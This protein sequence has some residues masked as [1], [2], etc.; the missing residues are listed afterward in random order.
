MNLF[1]M[2][3]ELNELKAEQRQSQDA[4]GKKAIAKKIDSLRQSLDELG[5]T[6]DREGLSERVIYLEA[7]PEGVMKLIE[8][9][10]EVQDTDNP[11]T[12]NELDELTKELGIEEAIFDVAK[13]QLAIKDIKRLVPFMAA[14][15]VKLQRKKRLTDAEKDE[16]NV[17]CANLIRKGINPNKADAVQWALIAYNKR[18]V[19]HALDSIDKKR[20]SMTTQR[21]SI[22]TYQDGAANEPK[23][24]A[25][26]GTKPPRDC[27]PIVRG[28]K[29][30]EAEMP[31]DLQYLGIRI[32]SPDELRRILKELENQQKKL[33]T[34]RRS[35]PTFKYPNNE[36]DNLTRAERQLIKRNPDW[37]AIAL[38]EAPDGNVAAKR[39]TRDQIGLMYHNPDWYKIARSEAIRKK[40]E[41]LREE[42]AV[43]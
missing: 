8:V 15:C 37:I 32:T 42:E 31:V 1:S 14:R 39:L 27:Q 30:K 18:T 11:D 16:Y 23:A 26:K 17:L 21:F 20:R 29:H 25:H 7:G 41:A 36:D 35:A 6:P 40:A 38:G 34:E 33:N 4:D 43:G 13:L 9:A 3:N 5:L 22:A 19:Q 12:P 10:A 2:V 28:K 24:S